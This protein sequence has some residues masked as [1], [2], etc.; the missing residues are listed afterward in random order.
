MSKILCR[1]ILGIL[2]AAPVAIAIGLYPHP[3]ARGAQAT[4]YIAAAIAIVAMG[5]VWRPR[6]RKGAEDVSFLA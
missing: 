3:S 5:A 1:L 4:M 6:R 2:A